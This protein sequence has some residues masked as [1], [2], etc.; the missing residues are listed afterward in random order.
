MSDAIIPVEGTDRVFR[1]SR[2]L[3]VLLIPLAM[4]LMAV[5]SINVA[6]PTIEVGLGATSSDLQWV[7]AG[8][9]L[10]F[11]VVLIPAGRMGD[12]LGRGSVF[13][14]GVVVFTL[15]SLACGLADT[16]L[17]LNAARFVQGIGAGLFGPPT[18]GMIQQYF[19]GV[20]RARAFALFGIAVS[21]SVAVAPVLAGALIQVVGPENGWRAVF[22]LNVPLGVLGLGLG[23][24]WFPFSQE[25]AALARRRR[26]PAPGA[27][28]R[29][30]ADLDPVGGALAASGVLAVMWPFLTR[31]GGLSWALVPLGLAILALWLRW[32]RRYKAAG[33]NPMVDLGL[34]SHHSFTHGTAVSAAL[35]LGFTSVFAVLA[36]H[37]QSGLGVGAL[38]TGLVGLPNAVMSAVASWWGGRHALTRGRRLVVVGLA[39][40]VAGVLVSAFIVTMVSSRGWSF[41]WLAV[42]L[43]AVGWGMGVTT[44]CNQTLAMEDI[45]PSAGGTAGGVK[46]TAERIGT[47]VGTAVVTAVFFSVTASSSSEQGFVWAYLLVACFITVSLLLALA[48]QRRARMED[49]RPLPR[50]P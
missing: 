27:P 5:S 3:T 33:R 9:A 11:G 19:T 35:F 8:Y 36:I 28:S 31:E 7:L 10:T 13:L 4:S 16:P 34:F 1:R 32:E 14:A 26:G 44:S 24:A 20:A 42:P 39:T 37:L 2:V 47:A 15:S 30:R 17:Q 40:I 29:T 43:S 21:A 41:W 23:L 45:P 25:R 12:V 22:F 18:I 38:A 49:P 46:Q 48:D 6:L 50:V